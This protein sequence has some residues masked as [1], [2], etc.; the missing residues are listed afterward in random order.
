MSFNSLNE[1]IES[2]Q[3]TIKDEA[4]VNANTEQIKRSISYINHKINS[5]D[6]LISHPSSIQAL[7]TNL[8]NAHTSLNE[9]I[10]TKEQGKLDNSANQLLE[11]IKNS[12]ALAEINF[13]LGKN[14]LLDAQDITDEKTTALK[15]EIAALEIE[16]TSLKSENKKLIES[17]EKS[18]SDLIHGT[19]DKTGIAQQVTDTLAIL[20]EKFNH[21][22]Y[23]NGQDKKG[24]LNEASQLESE[25]KNILDEGRNLGRIIGVED[26]TKNDRQRNELNKLQKIKASCQSLLGVI[27]LGASIGGYQERANKEAFSNF[28]WTG[29]ILFL[30]AVVLCINLDIMKSFENSA[31]DNSLQLLITVKLITSLPFIGFM[32]FA[33]FKAKNHRKMELKYRQFELELAAFEPNLSNLDKDMRSF[34][35]LMF[36]QKTFG[37]VDNHND[38]D[39]SSIE[40]FLAG[41]DKLTNG[42]KSLIEKAKTLKN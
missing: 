4:F 8:T 36:I 38:I 27:G 15:T 34:A 16:I 17:L 1:K 40:K 39:E 12:L 21:E 14:Y 41:I 22:L 3:E 5:S 42:F 37:H 26:F 35:K 33:G 32:T 6:S 30:F 10:T 24:W 7:L 19:P 2:I 23:G 28:I 29:L 13:A 20:E 25:I 18:Y 31:K 9:Y 11:A